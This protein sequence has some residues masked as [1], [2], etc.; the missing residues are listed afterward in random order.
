MILT[1]KLLMDPNLISI[2][3]LNYFSESVLIFT[4]YRLMLAS[5]NPKLRS[6]EFRPSKY[7]LLYTSDAADE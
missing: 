6:V 4:F 1:A 3:K 5:W 2:G 7:C